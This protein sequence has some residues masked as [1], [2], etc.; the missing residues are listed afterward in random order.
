[1]IDLALADLKEIE[2]VIAQLKAQPATALDYDTLL[3]LRFP[4]NCFA[5]DLS[6][7]ERRQWLNELRSYQ[8][9]EKIPE[10]LTLQPTLPFT[11]GVSESYNQK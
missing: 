2:R 1:M 5:D 8:R 6:Q 9:G 10:F 7:L 11:G 4:G 3:A